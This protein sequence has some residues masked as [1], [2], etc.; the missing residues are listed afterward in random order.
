MLSNMTFNSIVADYKF[1]ELK[2]DNNIFKNIKQ[3]SNYKKNLEMPHSMTQSENCTAHI[4]SNADKAEAFANH[5]L[6]AHN[7]TLNMGENDFNER[8]NT[9]I[10]ETFEG[11]RITD[12]ATNHMD[13]WNE[14]A[15]PNIGRDFINTEEVAFAIKSRNA[16][17]SF[18]NDMVSNF[19]LKK[20]ESNNFCKALMILFNHIINNSYM[21]KSWRGAVVIPVPKPGKNPKVISNYRPISKISCTAKVFEKKRTSK[22]QIECDNLN[23]N[24]DRQFGFRHGKTTCHALFKLATE[25]AYNLNDGVPTHLVALDFEKAYDTVWIHGLVYKMHFILGFSYSTCQFLLSYLTNRT[26]TVQ[27]GKTF[28]KSY[29]A[30]A[31]IPQ[32]SVISCLLFI[33]YVVDFPTNNGPLNIKITQFADDTPLSVQSTLSVRVQEN[34]NK[35]HANT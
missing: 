32:G 6:R 4:N 11:D 5:F 24:F 1:A 14:N 7:L 21:P 25:I 28:A 33:I 10:T 18:G 12:F 3:L 34:I 8:V 26:Y 9:F 27:M 22:I 19:V 20:I 16:K 23:I 17:K 29:T 15:A 13:E 2:I 31:G 30:P 35:F